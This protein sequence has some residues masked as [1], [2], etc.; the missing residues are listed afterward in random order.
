MQS[1]SKYP[2]FFLLFFLIFSF[3]R[4]TQAQVNLPDSL[5][6]QGLEPLIQAQVDS[7]VTFKI[8]SIKK[9]K[10]SPPPPKLKTSLNITGALSDGNVNRRLINIS[11]NFAH[12]GD[13]MEYNLS[14]QY[15]Y[16]IQNGELRED[17]FL[18]AF[19]FNVFQKRV[20]YLLGFGSIQTSNLRKINFRWE[21]GGG[22][23][24]HI[25]RQKQVTFSITQALIYENTDFISEETDD[26]ETARLSTRFKGGYKLFNQKLK[27]NHVLFVQPSVIDSDNFRFSGNL[28]IQL[29]LNRFLSFTILA[30]NTYESVVAEGRLNNDF[31]I[32]VGF[33]LDNF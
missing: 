21:S 4:Q 29:P 9:A 3:F 19:A 17:D 2:S 25:V 23:G 31:N 20:V 27:I 11:S 8:D 24:F 1:F 33:T 12:Q 14:P 26:I 13:L 6:N 22:V 16:G 7:L 5:Q 30:N 28:S 15:S 18:G 10:Q 32:Q